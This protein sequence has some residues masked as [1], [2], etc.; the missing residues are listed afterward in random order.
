MKTHSLL[1]F[2]AVACYGNTAMGMMFDLENITSFTFH[3]V[4]HP[5]NA[6]LGALSMLRHP[7]A[8]TSTIIGLVNKST[9]LQWT[10]KLVRQHPTLAVLGVGTIT[11]FVAWSAAYANSF[12]LITKMST[13]YNKLFNEIIKKQETDAKVADLSNTIINKLASEKYK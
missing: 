11:S 7:I 3:Q 8:S 10:D 5:I 13:H 2:L 4:K 1:F 9:T 6:T 12:R